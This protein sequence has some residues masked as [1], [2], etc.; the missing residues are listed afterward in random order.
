MSTTALHVVELVKSLPPEDQRTICAELARHAED[1][2]SP[3]RRKLR[4]LPDGTYY[5]PDGIPNDDPIF[6][7]LEEIE[8]DRHRT[9]ARP[10]P[11]LD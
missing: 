7:I 2:G 6:K 11:Q 9:P 4:R 10:A 1:L 8:E 5:N 3:L